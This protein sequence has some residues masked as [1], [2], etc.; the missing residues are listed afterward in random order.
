MNYPFENDTSAVIKKLA[1]NFFRNN[2][3]RNLIAICATSLTTILF[4]VLLSVT[5]GMNFANEQLSFQ[6]AGFHRCVHRIS[7]YIR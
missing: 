5:Y 4:V 7:L 2:N 3:Q 6:Q 1:K